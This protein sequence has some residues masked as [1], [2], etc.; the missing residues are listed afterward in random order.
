MYRVN[1]MKVTAIQ[2]KKARTSLDPR[3]IEIGAMRRKMARPNKGWIRAIRQALGMTAAQLGHR[4][5][6]TQ[7]TISWLET[8][9]VNGSIGLANLQKA[10]EAMKCTLVYAIVPNTSLDEIVSDQAKKVA[11]A[12][13][14]PVEHTMAL[15]SQGLDAGARSAFLKNYIANELD[16]T[17]LWR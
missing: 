17:K 11:A 3:L 12:E 9:E 13:L 8:S 10:A 7:A 2:A 1:S 14:A 16:L 4:M 15:E 6:I 5:G